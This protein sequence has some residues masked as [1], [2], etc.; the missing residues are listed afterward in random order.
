MTASATQTLTEFLLARITED[1]QQARDFGAR[2]VVLCEKP[3]PWSSE[4]WETIADP[5]GSAYP[6]ARVLTECEV[7]RWMV[8]MFGV[9]DY[10]RYN[11]PEI[12]R[13]LALIYADHEDYR[14]EW[15]P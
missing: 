10:A 14:D 5:A 1:E 12:M 7:K 8:E 4:M 15:R 13:R 3:G 6:T 2:D 9:T 11:D